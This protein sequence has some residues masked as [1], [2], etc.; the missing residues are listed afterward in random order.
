MFAI[1]LLIIDLID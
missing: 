1:E